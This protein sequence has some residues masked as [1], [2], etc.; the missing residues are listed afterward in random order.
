MINLYLEFYVCID[1]FSDIFCKMDKYM[2]QLVTVDVI[3][4]IR[5]LV[6]KKKNT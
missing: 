5:Y 3:V 6:S 4:S 1:Y 2:K